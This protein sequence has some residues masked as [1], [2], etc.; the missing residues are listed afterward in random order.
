MSNYVKAKVETLKDLDMQYFEDALGRM[1]F[2]ADF[3]KHEI[4]TYWS[5]QTCDC[6][7]C[8]INSGRS[9]QMGM[10]FEE[11]EDGSVQVSIQADWDNVHGFANA[12]DFM[13][14]F[15]VEYH[16][17]KYSDVCSRMGYVTESIEELG[18]G[19]RR[20]VLRRAA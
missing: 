5:K 7:I 16:T 15:T 18:N 4:D 13:A 20:M 3:D 8:D 19:K 9:S 12:N 10:S 17:A 14:R 2:K 11:N 1:G 6:V